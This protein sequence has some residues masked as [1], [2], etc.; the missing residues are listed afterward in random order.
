[1]LFLIKIITSDCSNNPNCIA[2]F[3]KQT[4]TLTPYI[5]H[6][7]FEIN[8]ISIILYTVTKLNFST[9]EDVIFHDELYRGKNSLQEAYKK[10]KMR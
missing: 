1:M 6:D 4:F 7:K 5:N 3:D 2:L 10:I 9:K 8:Y